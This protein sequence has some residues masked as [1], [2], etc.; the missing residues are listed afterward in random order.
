MADNMIKKLGDS[1]GMTPDSIMNRLFCDH[2]KAHYYHLQT[3][4]YAQHK[5]LDELYESLKDSKDSICEYLLG[6]QAPKRFGMLQPDSTPAFSDAVLSKFL[7]DGFKF[8]VQLVE[9]AKSKNL[10]EL[11]NL[12]SNLQGSWTKA[13]YL[14]TL[15]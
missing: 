11:A 6:I 5:M 10:E 13:K 4:S 8:S 3:T 9:Y 15:K 14:N 1:S 7:D 12:A 2:S